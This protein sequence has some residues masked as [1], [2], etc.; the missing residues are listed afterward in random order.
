MAR[1]ITSYDFLSPCGSARLRGG[2]L[3]QLPRYHAGA[4]LEGVVTK[5]T[6]VTREVCRAVQVETE[7]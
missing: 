1:G 6:P 7:S 5:E 2:K 3:G 4:V